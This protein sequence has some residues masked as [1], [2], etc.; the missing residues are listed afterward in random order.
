MGIEDWDG[1]ADWAVRQANAKMDHWEHRPELSC[2]VCGK[3]AIDG[4]TL[5][6]VNPKG[7]AGIWR[8]WKDMDLLQRAKHQEDKSLCS[9]INPGGD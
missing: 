4:V 5:Y 7:R 9:T 8:C 6:R 1:S 2:E 3:G